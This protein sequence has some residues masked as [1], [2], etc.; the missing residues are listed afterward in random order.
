[1]DDRHL[2]SDSSS[3][4][5]LPAFIL[6]IGKDKGS[7]SKANDEIED[8]YNSKK[9]WNPEENLQF[10]FIRDPTPSTQPDIDEETEAKTVYLDGE[11]EIKP[12]WM[13]DDEDI[14]DIGRR[15]KRRDRV[16]NCLDLMIK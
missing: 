6:N 12:A 16:R 2:A 5:F 13:N 10:E 4:R 1:M 7:H 3:L 8:I 14:D 9:N 11:R 15:R